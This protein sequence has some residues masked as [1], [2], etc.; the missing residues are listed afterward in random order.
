M[1]NY[2]LKWT[3]TLIDKSKIKTEETHVRQRSQQITSTVKTT[4]TMI[5]NAK[6]ETKTY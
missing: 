5:L 2:R 3:K 1:Q 6:T 4:T